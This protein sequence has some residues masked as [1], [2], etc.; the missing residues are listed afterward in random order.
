MDGW[1]L[2]LFVPRPPMIHHRAYVICMGHT[3]H[4]AGRECV[5]RASINSI[6]LH[7]EMRVSND[8][9]GDFYSETRQ[10][11]EHCS[12]GTWAYWMR[13]GPF[14]DFAEHFIYVSVLFICKRCSCAPRRQL[15]NNV[16]EA[17]S[18]STVVHS[19]TLF[20]FIP[21]STVDTTALF[22]GAS[23]IGKWK[24]FRRKGWNKKDSVILGWLVT[25]AHGTL[26][27]IDLFFVDFDCEHTVSSVTF[28]CFIS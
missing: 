1:W 14:F 26:T 25:L 4:F 16:F 19:A 17:C 28:E 2:L 7:A 5:T 8:T 23:R 18:L 27:K 24:C 13:N 6:I 20:A 15:W 9:I 21:L 10:F 11:T 22:F 3:L 12:Y